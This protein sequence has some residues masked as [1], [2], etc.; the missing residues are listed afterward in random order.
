MHAYFLILYLYGP[1]YGRLGFRSLIDRYKQFPSSISIF[2]VYI[3]MTIKKIMDE[4]C[5]I[6][7]YFLS[8]LEL[9]IGIFYVCFLCN[10]HNFHINNCYSFL[11]NCNNLFLNSPPQVLNFH[12]TYSHKS[13]NLCFSSLFS[14]T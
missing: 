13:G 11:C 3:I 2:N 5:S 7:I 12:S 9:I 10:Y 1:C 6:P 14:C 8:S 4:P